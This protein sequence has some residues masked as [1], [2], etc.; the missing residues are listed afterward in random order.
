MEKCIYDEKNGLS[1]TLGEDG[2]YYPD[3][4]LLEQEYEIGRF[5]RKHADYLKE[6][7]YVTYMQLLNS[8]KLNEYLYKIDTQAM[9][10]FEQLIKKYAKM[11]GVTEQLKADKYM[12]WVGRM[13]NIRNAVKEIIYSE[14]I[15]Q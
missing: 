9:E 13:N 14:L 10:M 8:G 7:K 15:Y 4:A 1:Y 12:E 2:Y 6:H 5:G 3:L 11:Q